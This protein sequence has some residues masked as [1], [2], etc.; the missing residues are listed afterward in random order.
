MAVVA[1]AARRIARL[2]GPLLAAPVLRDGLAS[3][4]VSDE[5]ALGEGDRLHLLGFERARD[6]GRRLVAA[7]SARA[8]QRVLVHAVHP[9]LAARM[10]I[11]LQGFLDIYRFVLGARQRRKEE[12]KGKKPPH[13]LLPGPWYGT[14]LPVAVMKR[15]SATVVSEPNAGSGMRICW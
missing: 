11:A 7:L 6:I 3:L 4:P 14:P 13:R 2:V 5:A 12:R 8:L 9:G 15:I 1:A 10:E